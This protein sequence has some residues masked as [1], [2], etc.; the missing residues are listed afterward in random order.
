MQP[1]LTGID[2]NITY[3][4]EEHLELDYK[5]YKNYL[6]QL[7]QTGEVKDKE[8][9][10]CIISAPNMDDA[11]SYFEDTSLHSG[12]YQDAKIEVEII[13]I[14]LIV[15]RADRYVAFED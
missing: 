11:I 8:L 12:R 10:S 4:R 1:K 9:Y 2:L 6:Y 7:T 3:T 13:G 15:G 14:D 5:G